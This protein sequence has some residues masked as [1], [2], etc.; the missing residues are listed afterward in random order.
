MK[1]GNPLYQTMLQF[2]LL[3]GEVMKRKK[4]DSAFIQPTAPKRDALYIES[5]DKGII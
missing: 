2:L 4:N 3:P 5:S 1:V